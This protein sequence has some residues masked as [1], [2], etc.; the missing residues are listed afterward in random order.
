MLQ[1]LSIIVIAATFLSGCTVDASAVDAAC[2]A[3]QDAAAIG[4]PGV[5]SLANNPRLYEQL[6]ETLD[7]AHGATDELT[8]RERSRLV[9][10]CPA[11]RDMTL[12]RFR[13]RN[14]QYVAV[15]LLSLEARLA[16][17]DSAMADLAAQERQADEEYPRTASVACSSLEKAQALDPENA[18]LVLADLKSMAF[19]QTI[20]TERHWDQFRSEC[21]LVLEYPMADALADLAQVVAIQDEAESQSDAGEMFIVLAEMETAW[22]S[23]SVGDRVTICTRFQQDGVGTA[24]EWIRAAG[25]GRPEWAF[26]FLTQAC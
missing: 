4:M 12:E 2:V 11:V 26:V 13:T 22:N 9:R 19:R 23:I 14:S 10:D 20:W 24:Q 21:P 6:L 15:G 5:A 17:A 1:R 25:Y 18:R 7:V 16:E 3:V 8:R